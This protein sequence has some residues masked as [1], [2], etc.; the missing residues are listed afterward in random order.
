MQNINWPC[1]VHWK[2]CDETYLT[3][4]VWHAQVLKIPTWPREKKTKWCV[5]LCGSLSENPCMRVHVRVPPSPPQ[6]SSLI[7]ILM[8]RACLTGGTAVLQ[9]SAL[10]VFSVIPSLRDR[11]TSLLTLRV[12]RKGHVAP[13]W[14]DRYE[15]YKIHSTSPPVLLFLSHIRSHIY[16]FQ[17]ADH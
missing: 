8:T 5:S 14:P 10:P 6:T 13:L 2:F 16:N 12:E 17:L 3:V 4:S 15:R 1:Y 9:S 11:T 7:C